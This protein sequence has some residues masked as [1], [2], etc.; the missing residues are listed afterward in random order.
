[1]GYIYVLDP[2]PK[3]G[4]KIV[5]RQIFNPIENLNCFTNNKMLS[6]SSNHLP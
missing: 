2:Q 3:E 1:M 4:T 6:A 5:G